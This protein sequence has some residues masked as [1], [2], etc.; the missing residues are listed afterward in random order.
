MFQV[1]LTPE[2]I[3][4]LEQLRKYDQRQ[5]VTAVER[6]LRDAPE[7]ESRNLKRLRLNPLADWELRVGTFRV[8]YNVRA[9]A[10]VV[11]VRAVG[12]KIGGKLFVHGEE[13][14]L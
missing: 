4:D 14:N 2:A 1:E 6:H 9:D 10:R 12:T 3:E 11:I 5:V 13:Y 7:R 8:F